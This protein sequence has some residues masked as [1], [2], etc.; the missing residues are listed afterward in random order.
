[1]CVGGGGSAISFVLKIVFIIVSE[2]DTV[3]SFTGLS[4]GLYHLFAG[5]ST[6]LFFLQIIIFHNICET[7]IILLIRHGFCDT[8]LLISTLLNTIALLQISVIYKL[9]LWFAWTNKQIIKKH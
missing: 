8:I 4:S 2:D 6:F 5:R 9:N 3:C 7:P 1:V